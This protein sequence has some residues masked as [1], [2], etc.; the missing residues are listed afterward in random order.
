MEG[1]QAQHQIEHS[2]ATALSL[3][4]CWENLKK[5]PLSRLVDGGDM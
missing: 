1:E 3:K 2:G 5:L 4:Y